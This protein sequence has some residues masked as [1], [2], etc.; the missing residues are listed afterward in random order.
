MTEFGF[1][2]I[3]IPEFSVERTGSDPLILASSIPL[4]LYQST[5]RMWF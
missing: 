4:R 5:Q 3:Y 1:L 2:P